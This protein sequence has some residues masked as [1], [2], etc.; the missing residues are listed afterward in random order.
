M[1]LHNDRIDARQLVTYNCSVLQILNKMQ[2]INVFSIQS[3][4]ASLWSIAQSLDHLTWRRHG[5]CMGSVRVGVSKIIMIPTIRHAL[6]SVNYII[7]LY[8][9]Y[10]VT[11]SIFLQASC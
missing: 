6:Y 2:K 4:I 5:V 9:N 11:F 7:F 3:Y 8:Y 10:V 1:K